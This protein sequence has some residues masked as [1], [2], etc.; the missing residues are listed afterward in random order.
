M[1]ST[2][3]GRRLTEAHRQAQQDVR[4]GFLAEF[5]ALWALLDS[6]R[7]DETGPGWVRAVMQLIQLFRTDS[8][9]V[10][11]DYYRRFQSL[12]AP[13]SR[14]RPRVPDF[15]PLPA[16]PQRPPVLRP[17]LTRP[18]PRV[19]GAR[20]RRP[21][22]DV[23]PAPWNSEVRFE[24]D[25]S[26][27]RPDERR[28]R[29]EFDIP[30]IDWTDRDRAV[31]VSLIV[32]GPVGQKS[33][34]AR[35]KRLEVARDES[36]VEASGAAARHVLTGGR[37][38]LLTLL[39]DDPQALGWARVTDGD[40]CSFCAMLA[41]RGPVYKTETAAKFQAHDHCACTAEPVYSRSAPWPGRARE[42]QQLWNDHIRG[43]YS[44]DE[45]RR[46]WRRLYEQIQR[47]AEREIA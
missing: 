26:A 12:E 34:T 35:G 27:F 24:L 3:E 8:A 46:E 47:E 38:S 14:T 40:P 29:V 1:A 41:S 9:A 42:F 16:P 36:F 22:A 45:A 11:A 2:P 30:G 31:E 32:T 10:A 5:I 37:R 18:G 44:G 33:K 25:E 43:R 28:A 13:S 23:I 17:E 21:P 20:N 19:D 15:G 39:E 6:T 4:D 7:L